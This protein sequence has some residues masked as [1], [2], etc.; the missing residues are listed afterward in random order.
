MTALIDGATFLSIA[1]L[2]ALIPLGY[3]VNY[4]AIKIGDEQRKR[5]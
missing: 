5:K 4:E 2:I 3:W 1:S